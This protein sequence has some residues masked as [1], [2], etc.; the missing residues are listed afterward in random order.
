MKT[1]AGCR[2][3]TFSNRHAAILVSQPSNNP[4]FP[5]F[6]V[7]KVNKTSFIMNRIQICYGHILCR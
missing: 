3:V 5:G 6:G 2:I 1:N 7:K 4:I